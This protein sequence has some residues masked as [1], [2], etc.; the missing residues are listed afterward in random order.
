MSFET[1]FVVVTVII[2]F[3]RPIVYGKGKVC[4]KSQARGFLYVV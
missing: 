2:I 1:L 4:Q 3:P